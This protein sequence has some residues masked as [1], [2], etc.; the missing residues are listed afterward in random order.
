MYWERAPSRA[1]L[2]MRCRHDITTD[3]SFEGLLS[4]CILPYLFLAEFSDSHIDLDLKTLYPP[5]PA[6]LIS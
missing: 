2:A 5:L 4:Y 6:Q 3:K 1:W